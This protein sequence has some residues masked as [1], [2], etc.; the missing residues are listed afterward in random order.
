MKKVIIYLIAGYLLLATFKYWLADYYYAQG[1]AQRAVELNPYEPSYR[2]LL[3]ETY[4]KLG[5]IIKAD[6][7]LSSALGTGRNI[8]ILKQVAS[9][10]GEMG[11]INSYYYQREQEILMRA[12]AL[13]PTDPQ[14]FYNLALSYLKS[15]NLQEARNALEKALK[16]KPDYEKA[17][18]LF[19]ILQQ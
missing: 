12:G 2:V 17:G 18:E 4:I 15:G 10:Y 13:A 14:I 19:A 6:S 11:A 9:S 7:E 5:N 8:K 1:Y 3:A 16:L